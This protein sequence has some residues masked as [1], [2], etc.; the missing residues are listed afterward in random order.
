MGEGGV[1]MG[2]RSI[3]A[4]HLWAPRQFYIYKNNIHPSIHPSHL[5]GK[6]L[7]VP[8]AW[9]TPESVVWK[10]P[11]ASS[12]SGKYPVLEKCCLLS[13]ALNKRACLHNINRDVPVEATGH[14][15]KTTAHRGLF[16]LM[17]LLNYIRQPQISSLIY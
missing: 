7:D 1:W 3:A 9:M 14:H 5:L 8:G 4:E 6:G 11:T 2:R 13:D 10:A 17:H 16:L 15:L 12:L